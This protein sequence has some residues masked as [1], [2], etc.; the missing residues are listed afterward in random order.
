MKA[1][2]VGAIE[3]TYLIGCGKALVI[4]GISYWLE[5]TVRFY[6]GDAE[7]PNFRLYK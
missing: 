1:E 5:M 6:L 7:Y 2:D 4:S 3:Y